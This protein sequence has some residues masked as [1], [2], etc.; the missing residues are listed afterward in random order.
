MSSVSRRTLLKAAA[1]SGLAAL[2]TNK[3]E[4]SIRQHLNPG[5]VIGRM[6]GAQALV[7]TLLVEGTHCVFGI[8]GAQENELWDAMKSKRLRYLLVTHEQSAAFAADGYARSTGKPGVV[9]VVPGPGVTN[10]LTGI[11]EALLDSVPMVCIVGDVA[12]GEKYR[13]FQVHELP[14][15]E[16]LQPVTKGV[17]TV[18]KVGEI[19]DAVRQAFALAKSGEPGPTAVVVPYN[20]LFD[21]HK[22]NSAPLE[23]CGIPFDE[24]GFHTALHVLSQRDKCIGIYAGMGCMDYAPLLKKVAETMHAPVATSVSGKGVIN[25]SHPLAVGWGYGPQGTET[26]EKIFKQ[27]DIVLALGVKY[28]EVSTAFY[29]IPDKPRVIHVDINKDNLGKVVQSDVCVQSDAGLFLQKLLEN[30]DHVQRDHCTGLVKKIHALKVKDRKRLSRNYA[31][32]GTDPMQFLFCLRKLTR[33]DAQVF[34][35]VSLSEHLA[36]EGFTTFNPRTYFNPT[37]NQAMGWSIPAAIGAQF[38]DPHR[39]VVSITGDGCFLMTA[40]E[41]TTAVRASLPVKFFILDDQSYHYMQ[42]LQESAYRRTTATILPRLDYQSIAKGFGLGYQEILHPR[43]LQAGIAT[44]LGTCG[45]V[46]IRVVT[47][48][49][50]RPIRWIEAA[51]GR[52]T[53]E[54]STVQKAR[55]ASRIGA[56]TLKLR[57]HND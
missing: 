13:H 49:G 34:M 1:V 33:P 16:L 57:E 35:D 53:E 17:F 11:G 39:Q 12:R 41:T 54:L 40:I 56:R 28:S 5:W 46:L 9:C 10:A 55:F 37:D 6:T 36:A 42:V 25:E 18:D 52:F 14:N 22:F 47:D 8:P 30:K 26:A 43:D 23:P 3:T 15:I 19:P 7:E 24:A 21:S 48:Y 27:A 20:L 44:A 38:A 50:K 29:A 45:P 51:K 31:K 2:P 32:C 4:A